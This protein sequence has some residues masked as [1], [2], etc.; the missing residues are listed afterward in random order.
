MKGEMNI[1]KLVFSLLVVSA[2]VTG[3]TIF[4]SDVVVTYYPVNSSAN[5]SNYSQMTYLT[6]MQTTTQDI[7]TSIQGA[8][9][10]NNPL[11]A[12]GYAIKGGWDAFL[13]LFRVGGTFNSMYSDMSQATP[14]LLIPSWFKVLVY[15]S[16]TF[17]IIIAALK[18]IRGGDAGL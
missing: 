16:I 6:E 10:S 8:S 18:F 7:D 11:I 3:L 4:A 9:E 12:A 14:I 13:M 5:I 15:T 1:T 2:V 17:I